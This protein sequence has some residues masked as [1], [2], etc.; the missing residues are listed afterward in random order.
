MTWIQVIGSERPSKK[1]KD[2]K[3][4]ANKKIVY[5]SFLSQ[6]QS[7]ILIAYLL[8]GIETHLGKPQQK[9]IKIKQ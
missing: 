2:V 9:K 6:I 7:I 4:E 5:T 8:S 1:N 3:R